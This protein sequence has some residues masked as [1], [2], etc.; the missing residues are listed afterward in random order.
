[1]AR[2]TLFPRMATEELSSN[3]TLLSNFPIILHRLD[4]CSYFLVVQESISCLS[5][6]SVD[7]GAVTEHLQNITGIIL[8]LCFSPLT[9][10]SPDSQVKLWILCCVNISLPYRKQFSGILLSLWWVCPWF[11]PLLIPYF[12]VFPYSFPNLSPLGTPPLLIKVARLDFFGGIPSK[13]E[14]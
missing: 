9:F 1:M 12:P 6:P 13:F 7:W 8:F 5:I 11:S 14:H 3:E 10:L 2:F 4:V